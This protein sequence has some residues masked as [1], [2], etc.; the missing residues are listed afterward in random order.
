MVQVVLAD[1][2]KRLRLLQVAVR[3]ADH[4]FTALQQDHSADDEKILDEIVS[5]WSH[6]KDDLTV[7]QF[8][9]KVDMELAPLAG[10]P[11]FDAIRKQLSLPGYDYKARIATLNELGFQ[12]AEK[13]IEKWGGPKAKERL[14]SLKILPVRCETRGNGVT[15][16]YYDRGS[17]PK[18][19]VC[20][21][22]TDKVLQD[23]VLLEFSF[24]H[25][26]VSHAFPNWKSDDDRLSEGWLLALEI[27]WFRE[28][29]GFFDR[30]A[31]LD[32]WLPRLGKEKRA[33][34]VADWLLGRCENKVCAKRFLLELVADWH[35]TSKDDKEDLVS[36]IT[37]VMKKAGPKLGG[38]RSKKRETTRQILDDEL[39]RPC[40]KSVWN[41][42]K[43]RDALAAELERYDTPQTS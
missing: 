33:F 41:I 4:L 24:F 32:A 18:L 15:E 23:C 36:L 42:N 5:R 13:C 37:G 31:L 22:S 10:Q 6:L 43:L 35:S 38:K 19:L 2:Q 3:V 39:C 40:A 1:D 20:P 28:E 25:E 8:I 29:F 21:G 16:L 30:Q 7:V 12:T 34:H 9:S 26:Y 11:I 27:E 17:K 14:K